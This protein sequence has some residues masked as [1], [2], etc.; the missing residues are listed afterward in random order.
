MKKYLFTLS[1]VS[2]AL[3]AQQKATGFVFEDANKNGIKDKKEHGIP[4][5]GVSNGV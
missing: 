5:V 3:S 4:N 2:I 1:L